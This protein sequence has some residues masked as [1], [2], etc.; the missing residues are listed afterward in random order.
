MKCKGL[1][2]ILR[3]YYYA[4]GQI[5]KLK[6][7]SKLFLNNMQIDDHNTDPFPVLLNLSETFNPFRFHYIFFS[8]KIKLKKT[9]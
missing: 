4:L 3:L 8:F 5:Q 9:F 2:G 1:G 6:L 7:M